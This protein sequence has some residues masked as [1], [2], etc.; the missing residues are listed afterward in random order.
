VIAS[1]SLHTNRP[2]KASASLPEKSDAAESCF[3]SV[4]IGPNRQT[5]NGPQKFSAN[6][7][8]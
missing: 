3:V 2:V 6:A 8:E 5:G 7:G 1:S 4:K